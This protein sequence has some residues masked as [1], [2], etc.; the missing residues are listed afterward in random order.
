[1]TNFI[2]LVGHDGAGKSTLA[3]AIAATASRMGIQSAVVGL[4][5]ELREELIRLGYSHE[6]VYA[7][8]TPKHIRDLLRAHGYARRVEEGGDYW[9]NK[10]L[11]PSG[12]MGSATAHLRR[13]DIIATDD[14]RH[15]NEALRYRQ[16]GLLVALYRPATDPKDLGAENETAYPPIIHEV[17]ASRELAQIKLDVPEMEGEAYAEWLQYQAERLVQACRAKPLLREK[18]LSLY[19][20]E[21]PAAD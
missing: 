13:T 20:P 2:G 7:K 10:V 6:S 12:E 15:L 1:M 5:K 17:F 21:A 3:K 11:L 19:E 9:L 4:A 16:H 14:V 8:P 18:F